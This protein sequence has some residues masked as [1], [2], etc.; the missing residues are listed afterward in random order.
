MKR[1]QVSEELKAAQEH[2]ER[3]RQRAGGR[4]SR[5]PEELWGEA[6]GLARVEGVY[7]TAKA[8]RLNY[9]RLRERVTGAGG[10]GKVGGKS[11]REA[12][13]TGSQLVS[14]GFIDLGMAPLGGGGKTV[15]ELEGRDGV[16][17]RIDV[18]GATG[19]DVV[20]LARAFWIRP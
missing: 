7:A 8:L 4:G 13:V 17:M 16:R 5:I 14:S 19:V 10:T 3:W 11:K 18:G 2:V 1:R 20:A 9:E 15:V 12:N 6:I